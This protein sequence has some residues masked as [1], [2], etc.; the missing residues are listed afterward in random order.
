[1]LDEVRRTVEHCTQM[2]VHPRHPYGGDLVYTSFSGSHQDALKKAFEARDAEAA[3]AG[4]SSDE[5]IW[6]LTQADV[7]QRMAAGG[8]VIVASRPEAFRS[9]V[10]AEIDRWAKAVKAS[11]AKLD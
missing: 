11:G 7:R 5:L 1:L 4:V 8:S 9:F 10:Q 3:A 6:A 2:D